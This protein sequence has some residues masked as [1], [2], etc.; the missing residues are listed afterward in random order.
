M[1]EL[2]GLNC[3]LPTA[4]LVFLSRHRSLYFQICLSGLL[5]C[6]SLQILGR[7][8]IKGLVTLPREALKAITLY[9][10]PRYL[11]KLKISDANFLTEQDL[12]SAEARLGASLRS[13]RPS[14]LASRR[15]ALHYSFL[16]VG[17]T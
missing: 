17:E 4:N 10:C 9:L 11:P 6:E 7:P 2:A 5:L 12:W 13:W 16:R 15:I 1:L 8:T 14:G 3:P